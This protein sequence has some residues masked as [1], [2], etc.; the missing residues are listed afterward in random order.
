MSDVMEPD[1]QKK[2]LPCLTGP[3]GHDVHL[4]L[5]PHVF[6]QS[7]QRSSVMAIYC[8]YKSRLNLIAEW[9]MGRGREMSIHQI[10]LNGQTRMGFSEQ[11]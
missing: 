9:V 8:Q 3:V 2:S 6:A 5:G 11:W 10:E 4:F 7:V 1:A